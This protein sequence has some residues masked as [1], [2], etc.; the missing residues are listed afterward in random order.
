MFSNGG[1][2]RDFPFYAR[3]GSFGRMYVCGL[4]ETRGKVSNDFSCKLE[5]V[6]I[7]LRIGKFVFLTTR[8]ILEFGHE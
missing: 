7:S 8:D 6:E 4:G 5:R 3:F 2:I 1:K